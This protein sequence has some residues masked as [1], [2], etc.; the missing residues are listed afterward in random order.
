[1]KRRN[2]IR[3]FL[4]MYNDFCGWRMRLFASLRAIKRESVL[5]AF[6]NCYYNL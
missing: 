1:M 3:S 4:V 5:L 6:Q 2:E